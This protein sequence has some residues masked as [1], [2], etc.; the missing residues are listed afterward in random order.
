MELPESTGRQEA[1]EVVELLRKRVCEGEKK[2]HNWP[3]VCMRV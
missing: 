3:H 2:Q 1:A